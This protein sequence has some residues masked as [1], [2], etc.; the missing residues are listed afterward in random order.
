MRSVDYETD[1]H[2]FRIHAA[3]WFQTGVSSFSFSFFLSFLLAFFA[4]LRFLADFLI[5]SLERR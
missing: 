2:L 1:L 5:F 4:V 3:W